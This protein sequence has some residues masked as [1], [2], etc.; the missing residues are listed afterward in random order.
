MANLFEHKQSNIKESK[1]FTVKHPGYFIVS[2]N[3][4]TFLVKDLQEM[5]K[6]MPHVEKMRNCCPMP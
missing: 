1:V 4:P 6:K 3:I 5:A 2:L